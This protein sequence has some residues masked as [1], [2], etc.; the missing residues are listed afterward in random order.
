MQRDGK[1]SKCIYNKLEQLHSD[2]KAYQGVSRKD[3]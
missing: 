2:L 3:F 1:Q